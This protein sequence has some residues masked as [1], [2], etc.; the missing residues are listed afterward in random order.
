MS[1]TKPSVPRPNLPADELPT[2][3]SVKAISNDQLLTQMSGQLS[4]L[5]KKVDVGFADSADRDMMLV[6][7]VTLTEKRLDS[8][9]EDGRKRSLR[10]RAT[11]D[12]DLKQDTALSEVL[13]KVDS[14]EK[15][16]DE[17][18]AQTVSLVSGFRDDVKTFFRE[19]PILAAALVSAMTAFAGYVS[20]Y[21]MH[22][23]H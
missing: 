2:Q 6:Q 16:V 4:T 10:V 8:L 22:G 3:P 20:S 5:V 21:F 14:L 13:V 11:S 17:N 23:G 12:N 7:R 1:D 15:K 18:H 9:E 19:N